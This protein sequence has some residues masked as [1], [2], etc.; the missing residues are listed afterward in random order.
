MKQIVCEMCGSNNVLKQDGM[1]VCQDCGTKYSVEEAKKLMVEGVVQVDHSNMTDNYL[2]LAISA[3]NSGNYSEAEAYANKVIEIDPSNYLGWQIKGKSSGWQSTL[4]NV[5]LD[6]YLSSCFKALQYG[7]EGDAYHELVE[8]ITHEFTDLASALI[9]LRADRFAK[10]PDE[11]EFNGFIS[12]CKRLTDLCSTYSS[13]GIDLGVVLAPQIFMKPIPGIICNSVNEAYKKIIE[14]D[15]SGQRNKPDDDDFTKYIQRIGYCTKLVELAI[16]LSKKDDEANIQRYENLIFLNEK[17][18][19]AC[20]Y[21]WEYH[22]YQNGLGPQVVKKYGGIPDVSGSG[23]WWENRELTDAAKSM[24]RTQISQY[25]A[26]IQTIKSEKEAKERAEREKRERIAKEEAKKRF[27]AYWEEHADEKAR[28]EEER[29]GLNNQ[30][31]SLQSDLNAQLDSF[32][33]DISAISGASEIANL[34]S[35]IKQLSDQK[36]SLGIFKGKEKKNLQEQ[37]DQAYAE[38]KAIQDRMNYERQAIERKIAAAKSEFEKKA[39]PLQSRIQ[40]IYTELTKAR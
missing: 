9:K 12:D 6:E 14:P 38:R 15:F 25:R 11:E 23:I 8:D 1:F 19:N 20:S 32:N 27:D 17:A 28:L 29:K 18:I 16:N 10:W 33:R 2:N 22:D 24:R 21:R 36:A 26:K 30:I 31:A 39:A 37:I 35:R 34:D 13:A 40:A 5:R 3:C 4:A 7:P